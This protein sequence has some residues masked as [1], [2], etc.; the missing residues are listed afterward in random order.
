[1]KMITEI[2]V[3]LN[4]KG[5]KVWIVTKNDYDKDL[6]DVTTSGPYHARD[7]ALGTTYK[8]ELNIKE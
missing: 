5:N 1:M 2:E 3:K 6:I 8:T 4:N 7:M